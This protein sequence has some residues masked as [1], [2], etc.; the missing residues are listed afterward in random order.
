MQNEKDA[1]I[2]PALP[3]VDQFAKEMHRMAERVR[4]NQRTFS[5]EEGLQ[6]IRIIQ[7][8]YESAHTGRWVDVDK[9]AQ[10]WRGAAPQS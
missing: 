10:P 9:P 2:E 5:P 8:I 7:T 3:Q 1:V 6:D 4:T